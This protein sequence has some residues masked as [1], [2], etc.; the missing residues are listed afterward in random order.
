MHTIKT[1]LEL[2]LRDAV[3]PA[4]ALT[5]FGRQPETLRRLGDWI[6]RDVGQ[7]RSEHD[8]ASERIVMLRTVYRL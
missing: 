4:R 1:S 3:E 6:L 2:L 5:S 8:K 7:D